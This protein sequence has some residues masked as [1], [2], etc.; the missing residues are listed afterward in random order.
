MA[1]A[2]DRGTLIRIFNTANG[3]K[4]NEV[5]RGADPAVIS[6]ISIDPLN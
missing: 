5:R 4:V 3:D 2:S 6:D 1:T